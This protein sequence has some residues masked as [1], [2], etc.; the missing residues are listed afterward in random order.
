[1]ARKSEQNADLKI[2]LG[3]ARDGEAKARAAL[4]SAESALA[5]LR[6]KLKAGDLSVIEGASL[7]PSAPAPAGVTAVEVKP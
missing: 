4:A 6:E 7:A 1:M 2:Q 3:R 5:K